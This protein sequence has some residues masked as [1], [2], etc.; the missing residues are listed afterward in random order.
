MSFPFLS[1]GICHLDLLLS[2]NIFR[3]QKSTAAH[4]NASNF[5]KRLCEENV[6]SVFPLCF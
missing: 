2:V 6:Y 4:L 5:V 1:K 3:P